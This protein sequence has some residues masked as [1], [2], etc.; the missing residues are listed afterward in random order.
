MLQLLFGAPH[1]V[2]TGVCLA[3]SNEVQIA[4]TDEAEVRIE[5]PGD[6]ELESYLQ[7]QEWRG[8]AGGYNLAELESRWR[9]RIAPGSDPSTVVGL[10][11][12]KL[13]P[14]LRRLGVRPVRQ[15]MDTNVGP[16]EA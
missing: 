6:R 13:V 15:V 8:K 2:V 14:S 12:R 4:L 1:R 3:C 11:M 10:P 16:L 5:S 7:S 9:I